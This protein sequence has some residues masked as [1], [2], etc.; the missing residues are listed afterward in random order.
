MKWEN[1]FA[2][3]VKTELLRTTVDIPHAIN[4]QIK[5]YEPKTGVLQNTI[6]ILLQKLSD[7]LKR[8]NLTVADRYAYQ[9]AISECSLVL[10]GNSYP[11]QRSTA[12]EPSTGGVD[13]VAGQSLGRNDHG[14]TTKV[15]RKAKRA[16]KSH[17][18]SGTCDSLG[19]DD[20]QRASGKKA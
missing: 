16:P 15:A 8:S 12:P 9:R 1:Q 20:K 19:S 18:A 2:S 10:G 7:E 5:S 11:E 4:S 6:S 17:D 3:V 13:L 14:G